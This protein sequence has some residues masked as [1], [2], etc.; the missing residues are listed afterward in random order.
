M[1]DARRNCCNPENVTPDMSVRMVE[2]MCN[3]CVTQF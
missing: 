1:L 2:A 3:V